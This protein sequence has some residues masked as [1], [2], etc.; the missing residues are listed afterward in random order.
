MQA[1]SNSQPKLKIRRGDLV[2]VI[3]GDDKGKEGRVL[4]VRLEAP[5]PLRAR[6]LAT[7]GPE[8]LEAE[9]LPHAARGE[10]ETARIEAGSPEPADIPE[11][12]LPQELGRDTRAISFDK[13][14]YLGQEIVE[15][16]RSRAQIHR[17]LRPLR[18]DSKTPPDPGT[19]LD[20]AGAEAGEIVSSAYSPRLDAVVAMAYVKTPY[21]EPET[22]LSCGRASTTV[23]TLP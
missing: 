21:A 9:G 12:T 10:L 20:L 17:I 11:K 8:R 19:K 7:A 6:R 15:R 2:R 16:V 5:C 22:S 13:G 3:A 14:C 23:L 1:K 18:I 4:E